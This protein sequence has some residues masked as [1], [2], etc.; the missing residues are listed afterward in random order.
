MSSTRGTHYTA[1]SRLRRRNTTVSGRREHGATPATSFFQCKFDDDKSRH[2]TFSNSGG[3]GAGQ[4]VGGV[5]G[6]GNAISARKLVAG[7]WRMSLAGAGGG[8]DKGLNLRKG[9]T[10]EL[11]LEIESPPLYSKHNMEGAT[12]WDPRCPGISSDICFYSHPKILENHVALV[13]AFAMQAELVQARLRIHELEAKCQSSKKK[14]KHL[15]KKLGEERT[16]SQCSEPQKIRAVI[17]DFDN[18]LS[19]ERIKHQ[20]LEILNSKLV[21]E[22]AN[23]KSSAKQ[24]KKDYDEQKRARKIM[25]KVCNEL[26]NKVAE[27]KA[28]AEAFKIESIKIQEEMEEERRMLQM[29]EVWRE[30]RVQMKLIDA[31]LALEDKYCQMNKLI[32]DLEIFLKSR[33]ATLDVMELRTAHSSRQAAKLVDVKDI[34]EFSYTPPKSSDMYS[35]YQELKHLEANER[36]IEERNKSS[37]AS[38]ASKLQLARSDFNEHNY[39]SLQQGS[40]IIID[41]NCHFEEDARGQQAVNHAEDQGSSYSHDE[42]H[43]SVNTLRQ[44]KND[45][46]IARECDENAPQNSPDTRSSEVYSVPEESMCKASS[47]SK[48]SISG[49]YNKCS[50][51]TADDSDGMVL[52]GNIS[53]KETY[54][55]R[56]SWE[57]RLRH[58]DSVEQWSS[59]ELVNPPVTHGL[60]ECIKRPRATQ[61][62]SLKAMLLEARMESQKTQLRGVLKQKS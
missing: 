38:N 50:E 55:R 4:K 28:E 29:A 52:S 26:A 14:I 42:N 48:L 34:K 51:I 31:K 49:R 16:S 44:S 11:G 23:V 36:E 53:D 58:Q 8:G 47:I 18:Q 12:K 57:Y 6:S 9:K 2:S 62:N 60:K 43:L 5:C 7:L 59:P 30:E 21:N 3:A 39:H 46:Q 15:M 32:T 33:I 25:E 1:S 27:D 40:T 61:N 17:G 19:K 41:D 37:P 24:F 45:S 10:D 54:P 22:L 13:P 35:I 56:K 20:K